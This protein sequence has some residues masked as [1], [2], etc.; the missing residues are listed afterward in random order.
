[1]ADDQNYRYWRQH[2]AEWGEEYPRRLR[3]MPYYH[4]QELM[5]LEYVLSVRPRRVLEFGCGVGRHLRNLATVQDVET[6]GYDQSPTMVAECRRWAT[7]S[8]LTEHVAI[9]APLGP[10]PYADGTFDLVFSAEVLV[11]VATR[12]LQMVLR[13]IA[14]VCRGHVLHLEPGP[15]VAL[16]QDAHAGSWYHD[17]PAAY[18]SLGITCEALPGGY[19][20]QT[21]YRA[22]LG[23]P[24]PTFVWAKPIL[25]A[26]RRLEAQ[27]GGAMRGDEDDL[28]RQ[29]A[30]LASLTERLAATQAENER[31]RDRLR[32]VETTRAALLWNTDLF[33]HRA[34]ALLRR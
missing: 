15:D 19:P 5:L 17:L 10:L 33:L 1:M 4:L 26:Y 22:V 6:F 18:A 12:D 20:Q 11:H 9:G 23:S 31:L 16:V 30:E 24:A 34:G 29:E 21:P 27:I 14:R 7:T 32:E 28:R 13:E 3:R 25:A 8:W 2:G